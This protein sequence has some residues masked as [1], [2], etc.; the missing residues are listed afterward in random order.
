MLAGAGD[1]PGI[2]ARKKDDIAALALGGDRRAELVY[3]MFLDYS[4]EH[5]S[6]IQERLYGQ[7]KGLPEENLERFEQD[8]FAFRLLFTKSGMAT[9]REYF[10]LLVDH[11]LIRDGQTMGTAREIH[12]HMKKKCDVVCALR[13]VS[14]LISTYILR[15]IAE[16]GQYGA[17]FHRLSEKAG[18]RGVDFITF[19]SIFLLALAGASSPARETGKPFQGAADFERCGNY[20]LDNMDGSLNKRSLLV[21]ILYQQVLPELAQSGKNGADEFMRIFSSHLAKE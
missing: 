16:V 6:A 19:N 21:I 18:A 8:Y 2:F 15:D 3:R 7:I 14:P 12:A 11:G 20:L 1:G 17:A 5:K 10:A 4:T 9:F 13:Y